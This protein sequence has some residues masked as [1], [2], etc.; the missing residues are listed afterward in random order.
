MMLTVLTLD[1]TAAPPGAAAASDAEAVTPPAI[2][3]D[4]AT[5]PGMAAAAVG[6]SVA[7]GPSFRG[8]AFDTCV[9]PSLDTMRR[10]QRSQYG[11]V[12]VYYGGRGR[13]CKSQPHLDRGW[14]RAVDRMGWGVLPVYVGSQSPC[15]NARNKKGYT[16]GRHPWSQ[17]E[18]E[19]R[20]AVRRA[21]AVGFRAGSPL[22]LDMEAY[23]YR[24]PACARTTLSFVR[25][26]NREVRGH[27]YIPGF[28]SSADSG[29]RH[30]EKAR[31]SGVRDL[32]TVMWFARWRTRP[33]LYREPSLSADAWRPARRIHQYAGNVRERHAGRTLVIDRNLVHAPVAR[34]G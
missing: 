8:K 14:T 31:R 15:V 4:T 26:W 18:R 22:Y 9:A 32:P 21:R 19:G 34:I 17:G 13:A 16:I 11:A 5:S 30:M 23:A 7:A 20:D 12:G 3:S 28:Y 25:S 10:W 27:G 29:V 1:L 33:H 24:K 6:P 2:S